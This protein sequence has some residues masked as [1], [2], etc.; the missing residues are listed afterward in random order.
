MPP[1]DATAAAVRAPPLSPQVDALPTPVRSPSDPPPPSLPDHHRLPSLAHHA[2]II[3]LPPHVLTESLPSSAA[4]YDPG[5]PPISAQLIASA[6]TL[7][8][9]MFISLTFLASMRRLRQPREPRRI[10]TARPVIY[11]QILG[12]ELQP[13]E[14]GDMD[15]LELNASTAALVHGIRIYMDDAEDNT[16]RSRADGDGGQEIVEIVLD[17]GE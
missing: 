9:M 7:I 13:V 11:G 10:A 6:C 12:G 5:Y 2:N 14:A 15:D 8:G 17:D 3:F 4:R 16:I 1:A